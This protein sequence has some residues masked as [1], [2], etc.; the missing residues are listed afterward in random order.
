MQMLQTGRQRGKTASAFTLMELLVV[1]VIIGLFVSVLSLRVGNILS[2]GDIRLACRIIIGEI[3]KLRGAAAYTHREKTLI[4]NVDE[5]RLSYSSEGKGKNQGTWA[6]LGK[7]DDKGSA[8]KLPGGIDL[9]DVVVFPTGK[10]QSGEAVV[11]FYPN[12]SMDRVLIH[13]RNENGEAYTL[14]TNPLTGQVILYDRYVEERI[15]S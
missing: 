13:L 14:E 15:I 7:D 2:G 4:F 6:G 10:V 8:I 1:L 11:K 9:E 5:E 12:G 3:T